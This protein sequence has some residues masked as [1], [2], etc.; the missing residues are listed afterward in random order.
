MVFN[1]T[2]VRLRLWLSR[3][4]LHS[5]VSFQFHI[6]SIKTRDECDLH[7]ADNW[8]Q[9]HIGSIKTYPVFRATKW[10]IYGFNSTLV[11]LRLAHYGLALHRSAGFNSTLVRLRRSDTASRMSLLAQFQFH[12]GSIKTAQSFVNIARPT[13][14]S[15]P[16][17]FD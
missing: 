4:P 9:F 3:V 6:G 11:R 5:G 16:H 12:I 17:W 7:A 14:V 8:F 10:T 2:L 1:S 13:L 15:I